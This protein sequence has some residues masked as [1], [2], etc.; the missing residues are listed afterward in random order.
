VHA[1]LVLIEADLGALYISA[2]SPK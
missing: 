2:R 1:S